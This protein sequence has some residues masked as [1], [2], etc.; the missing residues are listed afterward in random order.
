VNEQGNSAWV[1]VKV[2]VPAVMVAERPEALEFAAAA[3]PMAVLPVPL[4]AVVSESQP[5]L[6]EAVQVALEGLTDRFAN[7]VVAA[8]PILALEGENW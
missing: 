2:A 5:A 4:E 7:P 1:I 8:A 3:H 6:V